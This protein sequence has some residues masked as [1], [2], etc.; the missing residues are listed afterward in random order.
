MLSVRLLRVPYTRRSHLSAA[1][2]LDEVVC[3]GLVA[4]IKLKNTSATNIRRTHLCFLIRVRLLPKPLRHSWATKLLLSPFHRAYYSSRALMLVTVRLC[5]DRLIDQS[6]KPKISARARGK[7]RHVLT[8]AR[9]VE[10]PLK[11]HTHTLTQA[12]EKPPTK[13]RLLSRCFS[14]FCSLSLCF[15]A[16]FRARAQRRRGTSDGG[17]RF[18]IGNGFVVVVVCDE[19]ND[20]DERRRRRERTKE[21]VPRVL[22]ELS[23][24]VARISHFMR[25]N[26]T[27]ISNAQRLRSDFSRRLS[28]QPRGVERTRAVRSVPQTQATTQQ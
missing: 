16:C 9:H 2:T 21:C 25:P 4:R 17:G 18:P 12:R 13:L 26:Q 11:E 28:R 3:E 15:C 1:Q 5:C 10:R 20:D 19:N 22:R 6:R 24:G 7:T 14:L 27:Q 8:I 23:L